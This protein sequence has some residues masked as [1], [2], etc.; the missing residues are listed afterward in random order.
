MQLPTP[1]ADSVLRDWSG[2]RAKVLVAPEGKRL[3]SSQDPACFGVTRC[4]RQKHRSRHI[5]AW[6]NLRAKRIPARGHPLL[7]HLQIQLTWLDAQHVPTGAGRTLGAPSA[8][9]LRS[10]EICTRS[11]RSADSAG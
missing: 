1:T 7:E 11:I 2:Y 8:R 6:I 10:R 3:A 9:T 4:M 5:V